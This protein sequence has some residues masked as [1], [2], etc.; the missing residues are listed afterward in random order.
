MRPHDLLH[1]KSDT[2]LAWDEAPAWVTKSLARTPFVVVRR[3]EIRDDWIPVGVR[4]ELR[5]RR[6]PATLHACDVLQTI[7]PET[8]AE[9][10]SWRKHPHRALP[11]F[12]ALD[13]VATAAAN[14]NLV[15]GPCGSVG[16]ELASGAATVHS[17]SDLDLVVRPSTTHTRKDLEM[18]ARAIAD[19]HV[20]IDVVIE[21]AQGAVALDEW[22]RSPQRVLIKTVSG[23]QLGEFGW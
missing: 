22:L 2:S 7:K 11:A 18:F 20:R 4:G 5:S 12:L 9:A 14:L 23:P 6:Y 15:W 21:S 8:L 10:R 3:A 16:F 17:K 13:P 1:L 19:L